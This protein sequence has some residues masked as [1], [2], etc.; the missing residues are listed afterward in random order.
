VGSARLLHAPGVADVG[1][2][3]DRDAVAAGDRCWC[4]A[5]R[6]AAASAEAKW[7]LLSLVLAALSKRP[8]P[9]N[10]TTGAKSAS[11]APRGCSRRHAAVR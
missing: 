1:R 8:L 11:A 7:C 10:S 9:C 6:G 5:N 4:S 3:P 2:G